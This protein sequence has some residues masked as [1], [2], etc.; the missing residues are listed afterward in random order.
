MK[1]AVLRGHGL[2]QN[3]I[4][5]TSHPANRDDCFAPYALLKN[6]FQSFGIQIDTADESQAETLAYELHQDVQS[7]S[8]AAT[9]YLLMFETEFVKIENANAAAWRNYRKI[10]TWD[11]TLADGD[12]F[13]KINFP[14]PI[15]IHLEDG[16]SARDR[17]CCLIS[18]N[19]TLAK[20]DDRNLYPERVK[21][22][23]WF[24]QNA[25]LDF[26][27]YGL[28]W[29]RPVVGG[30]LVG[31]LERRF[32]RTLGRLVTLRPFPSY[33]GRVA[34]KRDVLTRTRFAICY[35]NVRDLPGYITEKIFDC[36]FSGCVPVYWGASNVTNHIPADCFVDRR[37]FRDTEEVYQFLKAMTEL[38]F[39]GYQQRIATFLRSDA[40]YPFGSEFFAET[41]VTTIMHDI[42]H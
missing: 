26:D 11:D 15:R 35:E 39:G 10:F 8:K 12:R 41:I 24:E 32:W 14:N 22:I 31:K 2:A 18:S 20:Q 3:I 23:R 30:G 42:G 7:G 1:F 17:F 34:H 21:A 40:A 28:D 4:F 5:D 16:F 6:K 38:E 33:R 37:Q 29:D 27:L 25:P 36:F 19:R 9:N 13:I